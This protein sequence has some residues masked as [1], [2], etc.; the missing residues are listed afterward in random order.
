MGF[1]SGHLP[2]DSKGQRLPGR[3]APSTRKCPWVTPTRYKHNDPE[4]GENA[5]LWEGL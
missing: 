5:G 2:R 4:T 1:E 3:T